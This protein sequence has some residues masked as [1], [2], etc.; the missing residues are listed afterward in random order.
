MTGEPLRRAH[1][2]VFY[3]VAGGGHVAAANALRDILEATGAYRVTLVNPYAELVPHLD[4]WKR[5]SGRAS[6][7]IYNDTIIREGKTGLF[8]LGYYAGVVLNLRMIHGKARAAM[9]AYLETQEPDLVISVIPMPNRIIFDA[10]ADYKA[11]APGR[12]HARAA[13]LITDWTEFGR[14]IWFPKGN[15]YAAICGTDDAYRRATSYKGLAGR[16]YRTQG[17]LLKPSFLGGPPADKAGAKAALGLDP[18]LPAICVLYGAQGS[19]RMRDI[20]AAL[21]EMALEAQVV[22]LCGHHQELAADLRARRWPFPTRVLGFTDEVP[23]YLGAADIFVGKPGPGSV[24]EALS[25]GLTLMVD[26]TMALP[27]EVPVVAWIRR[28]RAGASF[29]GTK[30]FQRGMTELLAR[31]ARGEAPA[32]ARPNTASAEIAGIVSA[33]LERT[34][35]LGLAPSE[36]AAPEGGAAGEEVQDGD[37]GQVAVPQVDG[38]KQ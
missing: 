18:K 23:S 31:A 16:V 32:Q 28:A 15:D 7:D 13:V 26:R 20:G 19:W 27:Q 22:F 24:S 33:I 30:D 2:V 34:E 6:E 11:R 4:L 35:A 29:K 17:L 12:D 21:A 5:L 38:A 37:A 10:L 36:Q 1:V 8:C 25:Y 9:A 14:H 3:T